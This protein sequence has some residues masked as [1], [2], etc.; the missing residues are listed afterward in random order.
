MFKDVWLK[1][2]EAS[3]QLETYP[4]DGTVTCVC[5]AYLF[6]ASV[7]V[8]R[9]RGWLTDYGYVLSVHSPKQDLNPCQ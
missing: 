6:N 5:V 1:H 2:R 9:T 7:C 8:D 3:F 4:R